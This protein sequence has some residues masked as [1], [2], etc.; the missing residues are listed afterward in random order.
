MF[1]PLNVPI[2][3]NVWRMWPCQHVLAVH[4][5]VVL[6]KMITILL[7]IISTCLM[8][9]PFLH[10][11]VIDCRPSPVPLSR[12]SPSTSYTKSSSTFLCDWL[13]RYAPWMKEYYFLDH[14][15][16]FACFKHIEWMWSPLPKKTDSDEEM[17]RFCNVLIPASCTP[18][19]VPYPPGSFLMC[20]ILCGQVFATNRCTTSISVV[21]VPVPTE[22]FYLPLP[23][24]QRIELLNHWDCWQW[25]PIWTDFRSTVDNFIVYDFWSNAR[26]LHLEFELSPWGFD[27]SPSYCTGR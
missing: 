4:V 13:L 21:S 24:P 5:L 9:M 22:E 3:E 19:Y 11:Q 14:K 16:Y 25:E 18:M 27:E 10:F 17:P 26:H 2:F 7:F 12:T 1:R 15:R 6:L 20:A 8:P 23:W